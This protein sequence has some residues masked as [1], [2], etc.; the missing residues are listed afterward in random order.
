MQSCP[1]VDSQI[2]ELLKKSTRHMRGRSATLLT[3]LTT[4]WGPDESVPT[5]PFPRPRHYPPPPPT[6]CIH[7]RIKSSRDSHPSASDK[8]TTCPPKSTFCAAVGWRGLS[9]SVSLRSCRAVTVTGRTVPAHK[10]RDNHHSGLLVGLVC[11]E[12]TLMGQRRVVAAGCCTEKS[13]SPGKPQW[14]SVLPQKFPPYHPTFLLL[15]IFSPLH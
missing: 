15:S 2:R 8:T 1:K 5:R 6:C 3:S 12:K 10:G 4:Q 14:L 11:H 13:V 9:F 7:I